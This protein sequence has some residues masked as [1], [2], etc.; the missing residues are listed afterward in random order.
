MHDMSTLIILGTIIKHNIPTAHKIV[1]P[2]HCCE[3][4]TAV[5]N[6]AGFVVLQGNESFFGARAVRL[7]PSVSS[8]TD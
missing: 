4:V 7:S 2:C 6:T 1:F 8:P 3:E 5:A